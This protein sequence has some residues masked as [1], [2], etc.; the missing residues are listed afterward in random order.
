MKH[1]KHINIVSGVNP[2][3]TAEFAPL[4]QLGSELREVPKRSRKREREE[5]G[6]EE[7]K[8]RL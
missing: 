2:A 8:V 7:L 5:F 3:P 1:P 4:A 6:K